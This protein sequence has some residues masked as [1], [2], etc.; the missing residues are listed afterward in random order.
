[1]TNKTNKRDT[2][3]TT[4]GI[5]QHFT[6]GVEIETTV[7]RANE[8]N[9]GSYSGI[10]IQVPYLPAGWVEKSLTCKRAPSWDGKNPM[11]VWNK[12]EG[13]KGQTEMERLLAYLCWVNRGAAPAHQRAYGWISNSIPQKDVRKMMRKMA[14]AYDNGNNEVN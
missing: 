14:K 13:R 6:F 1:M 10:G 7:P 3:D 12:G 2:T 4:N 11:G 5:A 9:I 8:L